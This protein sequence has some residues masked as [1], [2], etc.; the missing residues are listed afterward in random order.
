MMVADDQVNAFVSSVGYLVNGLDAAIQCDYELYV[1]GR[2][3]VESLPGHAVTLVIAVRDIEIHQRCQLPYKGIDQCYGCGTVHIVVSIDQYLLFPG[4]CF[5]ES[6]D[7]LV[8]ILHE[9]RVMQRREAG[10]EK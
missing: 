5:F 1:I 9:E 6:C 7:R 2:G 10:T 4:D 3:P 8:H